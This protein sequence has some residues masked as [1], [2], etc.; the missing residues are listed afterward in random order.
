M[1]P[2]YPE[3]CSIRIPLPVR[4]TIKTA[5]SKMFPE[6]VQHS[7][8]ALVISQYVERSAHGHGIAKP[9]P[10]VEERSG[11]YEIAIAQLEEDEAVCLEDIVEI[12]IAELPLRPR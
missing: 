1:F 8:H 9:E 12:G 6:S 4:A 11:R 7:A 5:R 2:H 10:M 3:Y